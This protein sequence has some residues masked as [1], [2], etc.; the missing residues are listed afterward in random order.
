MSYE[1]EDIV[2]E[3]VAATVAALVPRGR[4]L[5]L[6]VF[7]PDG[8]GWRWVHK[9]KLDTESDALERALQ[10][11]ERIRRGDLDRGTSTP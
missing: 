2:I 4:M 9:E 10:V 3:T 6:G 11:R 1:L 7:T 5:E 8:A